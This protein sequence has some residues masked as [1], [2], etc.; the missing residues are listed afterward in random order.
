MQR[1][2][3]ITGSRRLSLERADGVE[4][5]RLRARRS[6]PAIL[7]LAIW[8]LPWMVGLVAISAELRDGLD[9]S[10]LLGWAAC[11]GCVLLAAALL[12][13]Y[14]AGSTVLRVD[15]GALEIRQSLVGRGWLRRFE[16]GEIRA[17]AVAD[18]S[19]SQGSGWLQPEEGSCIRFDYRGRSIQA[20]KGITPAEARTIVDVVAKSLPASATPDPEAGLRSREEP[21]R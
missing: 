6:W 4:Q 8:L 16:G 7:F 5:I 18:A 11:A 14:L 12:A 1:Q 20:A 21:A 2:E 9:S 19:P 13:W 10:L 15:R 3:A 17:L